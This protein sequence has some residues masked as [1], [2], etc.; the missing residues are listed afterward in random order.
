MYRWINSMVNEIQFIRFTHFPWVL[1][2]M[3]QLYAKYKIRRQSSWCQL[4]NVWRTVA[5]YRITEI[6]GIFSCIDR[7]KIKFQLMESII[8]F[9]V[10]RRICFGQNSIWHNER[11][12]FLTKLIMEQRTCCE[13][14]LVIEI[15][16]FRVGN[17]QVECFLNKRKK[18]RFF[19]SI[20]WLLSTQHFSLLDQ[21]KD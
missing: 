16:N 15:N 7:N 11:I 8:S 21:K 14:N 19:L 2:G 1:A 5:Y 20:V 10:H 12:K 4:W 6:Y 9:N 3:L 17:L 18:L 13:Q